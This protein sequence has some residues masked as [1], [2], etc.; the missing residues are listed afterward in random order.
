MLSLLK[1]W[2]QFSRGVWIQEKKVPT[3]D[4]PSR[5]KWKK[6]NETS[7]ARSICFIYI[8]HNYT[9]KNLVITWTV[10]FVQKPLRNAIITLSFPMVKRI[11]FMSFVMHIVHDVH[12]PLKLILQ[13]SCSTTQHTIHISIPSSILRM[14]YIL[15]SFLDV[16]NW[17]SCNMLAV[18]V[19]PIDFRN[20]KSN[21][22]FILIWFG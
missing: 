8:L 22:K 6:K 21:K 14:H 13:C 3:T 15:Q 2:I 9:R 1:N 11:I 12:C 20:F 5:M 7:T 19:L 18:K 4:K 17:T 16:V 10:V